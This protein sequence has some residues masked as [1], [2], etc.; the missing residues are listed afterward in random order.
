MG[1][2]PR[3]RQK[4]DKL[5]NESENKGKGKQVREVLRPLG[6][7]VAAV[8]DEA[9]KD[10]EERRLE[11]FLFGTEFVSRNFGLD[12]SDEEEEGG[13][14]GGGGGDDVTKEDEGGREFQNLLDKD[15]FFIDDG[16]EITVPI[17]GNEDSEEDLSNDDINENDD[18]DDDEGDEASESNS[19]SNA[20]SPSPSS[21]SPLPSSPK[22][23]PT[24]STLSQPKKPLG[25][26]A[27]WTDPSD[28]PLTISLATN[29]RLRKLRDAP[30]EDVLTGREY[31]TRLRRQ[32]ERINPE[33][34]WAAR[35][36]K[37][38][39]QRRRLAAGGEG[40]VEDEEDEEGDVDVQDLLNSTTGILSTSK[41][42]TKSGA[43]ILP[44]E[45]IAI[46]RLRDANHSVQE[47]ACGE[48]KVVAFHPSDKVPV[49]C[50]GTTDRRVR[51]FNIDGHTS[52]LLQTLYLPSLPLTSQTSASFHP[53]GS[54]LLL[55]GSRPFFYTHDLQSGVTT[56]HKRGLWGTT[57]S[58]I[59]DASSLLLA[60]SSSSKK[61]PRRGGSDGTNGLGGDNDPGRKGGAKQ[62]G[63]GEG[64]EL[65]AF[66]PY[67]GDLLAVGG[68]AG[69]VHIVDWKSG[70][71]Q[72]IASLKCGSGAG[73]VKSLWWVPSGIPSLSPSSTVGEEQG[74][75][76]LGSGG[77]RPYLAA[78]SGD[79]EVYLWDVGQRRCVRR[80]KDEGG[81]RGAGRCMAGAGS[82]S[83]GD[84]WLA[85][86][87]TSGFVNVYGP[88][89]LSFS[90]TM[91][92]PSPKPLKSI[93]NLVTPI[94]TLRF[95]HDAQVL[96][97]ASKEKKDAFRLVHLPSLTAFANWPTSGTPLGH[98]SAVDFS[99][100]NEYLA[101]GNTRGRVLLYHLK[102]YGNG[103]SLGRWW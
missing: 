79:A 86:G 37:A 58:A 5:D 10:D 100:N 11:S 38:A 70:G 34:V 68:R 28:E 51:L 17:T 50:V 97:V 63:N 92:L 18:E 25:G 55:T 54:H 66:S 73:G 53:L 72:V 8:D 101:V 3:K 31:E 15:L 62:R 46:E 21:S 45:K 48:V 9:A 24:S 84:G 82:G 67:P 77:A 14:L 94:S 95:N 26:R 35:A 44:P 75:G 90:P 1:K 33:P 88:D 23:K 20:E 81:F 41:R 47:S 29:P 96:A 39:R 7:K 22:L 78:L 102:D 87:S 13:G 6:E 27:A 42:K 91:D 74:A 32:F 19:N 65:T 98:V 64:M 49:L 60:T 93:A 85:I 52:P 43:V 12:V 69:H 4:L 16:Q 89:S 59:S 56:P 99:A 36:R 76:D 30:E 71:G 80:W 57:F 83:G 103:G 61:R 2:R 40:I